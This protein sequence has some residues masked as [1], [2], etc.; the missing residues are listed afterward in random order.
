MLRQRPVGQPHR[1]APDLTLA[2]PRAAT[3]WKRVSANA[4]KTQINK[5]SD[6][7]DFF[8]VRDAERGATAA[9]RDHV[10]V[11]DLE[12]G[13][14]EAV[15]EVDH[16]TLHVREAGPVDEQ[17]DALIIE[18]RVAVAL[19]VKRERVLEP[20]TAATPH[21]DSQPG[22]VGQFSPTMARRR[23]SRRQSKEQLARTIRRHFNAMGV[24]EDD[25]ITEL[26]YNL[27]RE[28]SDAKRTPVFSWSAV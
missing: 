10:R 20:G 25:V 12:A 9:S 7:R 17:A 2:A 3:R 13:A 6:G 19:L 24:Q 27:E 15:D 16:R 22:G 14:L 1:V 26:L 4:D 5:K 28:K 18:H 8:L 23:G 11:L 21:P